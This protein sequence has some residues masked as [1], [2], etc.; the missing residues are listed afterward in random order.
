MIKIL[1][2][3]QDFPTS[4]RSPKILTYIEAVEMT[5]EY[6]DDG[7]DITSLG[8]DMIKILPPFRKI[9]PHQ[10]DTARYWYTLV[11][12]RWVLGVGTTNLHHPEELINELLRSLRGLLVTF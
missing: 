10:H 11:W 5:T 4:A 1:L 12:S 6:R 7:R 2:S 8:K 3:R 9:F